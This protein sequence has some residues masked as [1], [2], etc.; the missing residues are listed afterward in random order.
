MN[1]QRGAAALPI[2]LMLAFAVLL[3][4]AFSNRS[5]LLQ[6][7]SSVH[8][9][10]TAQAHEAAQAGLAWTL[11]QLNRPI[12]VGDDCRASAQS[13]ASP[14][15]ELARLG[16]LQASCVADGQGWAC[17]CPRSGEPRALVSAAAPAFHI[18]LTADA[19]QPER[20]HLV[21]TGR[22]QEAGRTITLRQNLG[23]LPALDT[24]P[25]AALAV[26]GH[27]SFSGE[28]TLTHTDA[29]SGGVT[30]HAGGS[31]HGP[32][33][34]VISAPG[35]PSRASML[36]NDADLAGLTAQGLHASVFRMNTAQWREQ[37][38]AARVS[39]HSP[40]DATLAEAARHHTLIV[41]DGGLRLGTPLTLG[42]TQR[43]VVLVADGA[44]DLHAAAT[45]HGLV[46]SRHPQWTDSVG[47]TV[48][49]AVIV[50]N[51]LQ[52]H[53][54]TTV[55]HNAAVLRALQQ[56]SGTYAPVAGSWR[57]L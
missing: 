34:R 17:H 54:N 43:P 36:S 20:W 50:E 19:T 47:S 55:H 35:T 3:A 13:S 24:L 57:D 9:L 48:H 41:L 27:A 52:A 30:L 14:W 53:G 1:T 2:T 21:S 42:S 32:A 33:L 12:P 11:A 56:R 51:D 16:P 7:R 28:F 22:G 4:V 10:H 8:Q 49:G 15:H 39:C 18:Q 26:R 6:V 23:R 38:A 45:V 40:C 25:A 29:S 46:Y 44:V 31:V 5:V 37:P